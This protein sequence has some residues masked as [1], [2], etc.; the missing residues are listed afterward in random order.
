[1]DGGVIGAV[2]EHGQSPPLY[3]NAYP[4]PSF[5]PHTVIGPLHQTGFIRG[6]PGNAN[7]LPSHTRGG[8]TVLCCMASAMLQKNILGGTSKPSPFAA[9]NRGLLCERL[10]CSPASWHCYRLTLTVERDRRFSPTSHL[11][12]KEQFDRLKT[13]DIGAEQLPRGYNGALG[14]WAGPHHKKRTPT[15]TRVTHEKM[16]SVTSKTYIFVFLFF[17]I[18][19]GLLCMPWKLSCSKNE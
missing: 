4:S 5:G 8:R 13:S 17:L 14:V 12:T 7:P 6:T 2:A 9:P 19:F 11:E 10:V 15:F 3:V 16:T 1:M 18:S